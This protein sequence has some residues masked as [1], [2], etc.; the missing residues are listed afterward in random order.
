[1]TLLELWADGAGLE[2]AGVSPGEGVGWYRL[3]PVSG[4]EYPP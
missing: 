1:M 3:A 4:S 2:G